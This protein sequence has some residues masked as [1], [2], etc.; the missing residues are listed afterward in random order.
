MTVTLGGMIY[1][2]EIFTP[3]HADHAA[4]SIRHHRA[5]DAVFDC[6]FLDGG[7]PSL[8]IT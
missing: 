5:A 2:T 1:V 7:N 4:Q 6:L 3:A 8:E